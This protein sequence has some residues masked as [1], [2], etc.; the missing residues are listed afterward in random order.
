MIRSEAEQRYTFAGVLDVLEA[1]GLEYMIWG[2]VAAVVYGE[3]RFTQDMDIVLKLDRHRAH[4]M[5]KA[6]E[7]DH[8]YVSLES[9]LDAIGHGGY[10]NVIHVYTNIKVDFWVPGYDPVIQWAFD[11]RRIMPFDEA[12]QAA[13][14]PPE[15]VIL[16]KLRTYRASDS[17]RHLEDIESIL[18]VSGPGL[19]RVYI[20]REALKMDML[21]TWRRLVDKVE[22][23]LADAE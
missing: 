20:E 8:Y 14:M 22:A 13:Y 4:L 11:H 2:G 19:D 12:R 15:A 6:L 21:K 7:E 23:D 10:F 17:T 5:A 1:L 9:M 18:R 16:T 3:P